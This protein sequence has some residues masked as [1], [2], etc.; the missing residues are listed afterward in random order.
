M[1]ALLSR[2]PLTCLATEEPEAH[3]ACGAIQQGLL[4]G[5]WESCNARFR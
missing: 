4:L 3:N 5:K 1:S 2:T